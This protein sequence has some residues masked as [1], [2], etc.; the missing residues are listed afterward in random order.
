[1]L[2]IEIFKMAKFCTLVGQSHVS[3][4]LGYTAGNN[5]HMA[6]IAFC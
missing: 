3:P 4:H 1:M 5:P 2:D 6:G